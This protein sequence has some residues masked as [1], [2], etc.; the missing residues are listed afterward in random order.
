MGAD[1]VNTASRSAVP[2]DFAYFA[3]TAA[4]EGAGS[5]FHSTDGLYSRPLRPITRQSA[6]AFFTAM[7]WVPN[8]AQLWPYQR[9]DQFGGPGI[10]NMPMEHTDA[11]ALRTF[12]K[13]NGGQEWCVA[14]RPEAG[15]VAI[16]RDGWRIVEQTG[17]RGA[18]VRL[19][20]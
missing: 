4:L 13:G 9:G 20:R 5:T 6:Q 8:D 2:D 3:A 14:V 7:K 10:N 16:A 11:L 1:E 17:P 12:C 18:L 15:W 19:V